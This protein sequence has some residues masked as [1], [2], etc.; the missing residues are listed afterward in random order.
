M[1]ERRITQNP[2]G[3]QGDTPTFRDRLQSALM[4][5]AMRQTDPADRNAMLQIMRKDGWL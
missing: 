5:I 4:L 2:R 1:F 3:P